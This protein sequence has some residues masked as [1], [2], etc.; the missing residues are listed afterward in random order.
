LSGREELSEPSEEKYASLAAFWS[1]G[2]PSF[3]SGL[4]GFEEESDGEAESARKV[5]PAPVRAEARDFRKPWA[6]EGRLPEVPRPLRG[7]VKPSGGGE[8]DQALS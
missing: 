6:E 3:E 2:M 5:V 8:G 1:V 4:A 7:A